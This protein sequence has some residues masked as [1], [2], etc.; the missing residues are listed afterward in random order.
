MKKH[1]TRILTALLALA[2]LL[3]VT[4]QAAPTD[5]WTEPALR[6]RFTQNSGIEK[7]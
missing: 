7:I 3:P 4:A 2:M 1:L 5:G 6:I